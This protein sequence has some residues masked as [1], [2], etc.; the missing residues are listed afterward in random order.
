MK[1]LVTGSS[2][3]VGIYL[4]HLL[5]KHGHQLVPISRTNFGTIEPNTDW[6]SVI[7]NVEIVIHLAA[8]VHLMQDTATDQLSAYRAAN[9][10]NTLNLARQAANMGMKRFIFLSSIKV[11]GEG[12]NIP[13]TEQDTPNPT[14][15]YAISKWEAEQGLL[16]IAAETGMEVVILR[17]PLV[18]GEGVKANFKTMMQWVDKGLPLP[19]GRINNQRSL[20][21]IGN[22]IDAIRICIDHPK[23]ANQTFLISDGI[24]LSTSVLLHKLARYLQ[25]PSRLFYLPPPLLLHSLALLG[26][27]QEAKRLLSSLTLSNQLIC[28]TLT[29]QPPYSTD[30]GLALTAQAYSSNDKHS[31]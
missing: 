18:Y 10:A 23:A 2:G 29:W 26:K 8:R 14:D 21:Y 1:I 19:F 6:N 9:T 11:N 30:S 24:P 13:Y 27:R 16:K 15:P 20:L 12:R 25:R 4:C 28:N 31:G 22:L 3:F 7:Q 17:P 5:Q